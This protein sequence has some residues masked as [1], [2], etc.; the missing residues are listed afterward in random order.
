M[1]SKRSANRNSKGNSVRR[2]TRTEQQKLARTS[3]H[4]DIVA[5]NSGQNSPHHAERAIDLERVPGVSGPGRNPRCLR[6]RPGADFDSTGGFHRLGSWRA[7]DVSFFF[8]HDKDIEKIAVASE[9]VWRDK[10]L[11]FLFADYRQAEVRFFAE[12]DLEPARVWLEG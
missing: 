3:H 7:I 10:M 4:A 11:L 9:P 8:K 5:P 12:T 6:G 1:R 2:R